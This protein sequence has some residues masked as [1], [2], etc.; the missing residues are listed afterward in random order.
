MIIDTAEANPETLYKILTGSI[1]PRP[2]AWVSTI[3]KEGQPNLAPFSFFTVASCNPPILCFAPANKPTM[4]DE[5][6]GV[7][8]DTLRNIRQTGEFVVNIVSRELSEKMT[9]TSGE[10]AVGINEFNA[11]GL[12]A[13]ASDT[14]RPPRVGESLINMECRL[15]QILEFGGHPGAGNLVLGQLLRI[16]LNDS[17]YKNGKIDLGALNPIGRL[18]GNLYCTVKD[19]FEMLRPQVEQPNK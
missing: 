17:V 9:Q 18:S 3:D 11:A 5:G 7:P 2:I 12:T 13:V 6:K 15:H 1:L 4:D 16:H 8:K 14:V 19:R 10:Y